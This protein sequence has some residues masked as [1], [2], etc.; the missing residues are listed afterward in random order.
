MARR[1]ARERCIEEML[2]GII[3]R[4]KRNMAGDPRLTARGPL[5]RFLFG[6]S[7]TGRSGLVGPH[8]ASGHL[9]EGA[10]SS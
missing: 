2:R 6:N 3:P 7:A 5:V 9:L 1:H 8:L 4:E 10:V